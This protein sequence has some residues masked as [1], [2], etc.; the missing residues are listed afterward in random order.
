MSGIKG[1]NTETTVYVELLDEGVFVMRPAVGRRLSEG[2]YRLLPTDGYDPEVETWR[3]APGSAVECA[4]ERHSG[5][6]LLVAKRLADGGERL[7]AVR[8]KAVA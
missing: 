5:E 1:S 6:D 3:F 8:G 7:S 4:W 2:I